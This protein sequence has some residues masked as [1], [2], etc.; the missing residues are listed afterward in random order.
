[1][2]LDEFS[3]LLICV[4]LKPL[5]FA[6]GRFGCGVGCAFGARVT[7]K[8]EGIMAQ[9]TEAVY[10][11]G[12]LKPTED[13]MLHEAQRVRLIVEALDTDTDRVDRAVAMERLRV[14]IDGMQFVSS[15]S[16]PSRDELHDRP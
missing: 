15:G 9:F 4:W 3:D 12:V 6:R 10:T 8:G 7:L 16:L 14:G 11:N 5:G 13:L 2:G 1:L